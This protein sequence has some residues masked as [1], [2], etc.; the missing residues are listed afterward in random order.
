MGDTEIRDLARAMKFDARPSDPALDFCLWPYVRPQPVSHHSSR[1]SKIFFDFI[2]RD[3]NM[4][5]LEKLFVNVMHANGAFNTVWGLKFEDNRLSAELYFYDYERRNRRIQPLDLLRSSQIPVATN[6]EICENSDF[7]M[8]SFS[9]EQGFDLVESIDIYC[10]GTGGTVSGGTC[11]SISGSGTIL[12][13][14]Y[15]FFNSGTDQEAIRRQIEASAR[16]RGWKKFPVYLLPN[17]GAEEIYV[18][19]LKR[20]CDGI[21]LSRVNLENI[22]RIFEIASPQAEMI[23]Y[24]H[25][26]RNEFDHHLFDIGF[27]LE[28]NSQGILVPG[29][30][31]IYGIF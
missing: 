15:Y 14:L 3:R 12:K 22:I 5:M 13:N 11:Y 2:G 29:K 6:L 8:W 28:T 24:L 19:A 18:F 4:Q 17:S 25:E 27:D 21:Y 10:D 9:V 26:N 16:F 31:A 23:K 20:Y 7:F 1:Q 30:F